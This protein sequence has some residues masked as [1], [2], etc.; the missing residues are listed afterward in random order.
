MLGKFKEALKDLKTVRVCTN[1]SS[2]KCC[3]YASGHAR[4]A[5]SLS[6]ST[7]STCS[8]SC[9]RSTV[10]VQSMASRQQ[11]QETVPAL[12][13]CTLRSHTP[14]TTQ[15]HTTHPHPHTR[16]SQPQSC[17]PHPH[18]PTPAP[19]AAKVAPKDPDLRKK[20]SECER[21]VKRIRFEEAL[22]TPVSMMGLGML[23][24]VI[25]QVAKHNSCQTQMFD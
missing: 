12:F 9:G 13:A 5:K 21:A 7:P 14:H 22:S 24:F 2:R 20:L 6:M 25:A 23:L 8:S 1:S 4:T 15:Q 10:S 11:Q 18:P 3:A 19:Q 16:L 17:T